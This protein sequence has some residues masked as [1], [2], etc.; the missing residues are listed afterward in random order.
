MKAILRRCRTVHHETCRSFAYLKVLVA[1]VVS[2][3]FVTPRTVARQTPLSMEFSRQEYWSGL[4][5]LSPGDLP[6]P[7]IKPSSQVSCTAGRFFTTSATWEAHLGVLHISHKTS[8]LTI[9]QLLSFILLS[10]LWNS[11]DFP[12][13]C[14]LSVQGTEGS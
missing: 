11:S 9:H 12:L 4:S 10:P 3:S 6:D 8:T 1:S 7:G 5:I 2:D 14:Y 13:T